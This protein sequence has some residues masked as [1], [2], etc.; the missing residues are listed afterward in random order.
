[1]FSSASQDAIAN[2]VIV[3]VV[4]IVIVLVVNGPYGESERTMCVEVEGERL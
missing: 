2:I 1:M 4:F 3:I